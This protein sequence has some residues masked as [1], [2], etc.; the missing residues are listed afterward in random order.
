MRTSRRTILN[1]MSFAG[2]SNAWSPP[3]LAASKKLIPTPACSIEP[4]FPRVEWL[5]SPSGIDTQLPRFTWTLRTRTREARNLRQSAYRLLVALS[6]ALL[7]QGHGDIWDSGICAGGKL[8]ASPATTLSLGSH[9]IY[10]WTVRVWDE[11]NRPSRWAAPERFVTGLMD[12][13]DWRAQWIAAKPDLPALA[14]PPSALAVQV[15]VE[16]EPMPVFRRQF[17]L[18]KQIRFAVASTSGLGQYELLVNAQTVGHGVLNPGWTD[19]RKTVLYNTFD[20]TR[21]LRRGPNILGVMLGNG[22]YNVQRYP[23]RYTKFV[24]T[25]GQPKLILQLKII[26]MDGSEKTIISDQSWTTRPGP[27]LLSS[28]YGGEDYDARSEPPAWDATDRNEDWLPACEVQ[29]PGGVLRAQGIPPV[30]VARV[31]KPVVVTQP[32]PGV[33]VYDLGRNFAGWPTIVVRGPAGKTVRLLPAELL[34]EN[35]LVTQQS[36]NARPGNDVEFNYT[37]KGHGDEAWH[38]RFS[39][40]GF[41]YVQVEGAAPKEHAEP[42][43]PVLLSL[44]GAFLHTA[45]PQAGTFDSSDNLLAR[46]HCLIKNAL[47][48]NTFSVLTD[49]PQREKLGWL[50]Q[51]Y[52]NADTVFYN[53]DAVTIYEKMLND[54]K[55]SQLEDGLV[56][57][58]APEYVAFDTPSLAAFRDSPE[59]GSAVVL[60]PWAAYRRYGNSRILHDG[61]SA[62]QRYADYLQQKA[63]GGLLDYGLGDW[64]DIGPKP[65][66]E[67]QLT[68]KVLTATATYYGMLCTL[69][70]IAALLDKPDNIDDYQR[71]AASVKDAFNAKLFDPRTGHYDRNSQ[72]ANAMPLVLGLVPDGQRRAVLENLVADIRARQN[73]VSAGDIGFHYVVQALMEGGRG[74]VLFDMLSRTDPPSYAYQLAKGATALTEA[75]DANPTKSQD[76]F[77]LGHAETWFYGGL[78]GVRIDMS[79]PE[80]R[81]ILIAPQIVAGVAATSVRYRSVLGDVACGWRKR[82][83]F[84]KLRVEIPAGACGRVLLAGLRPEKIREGSKELSRAYG[85]LKTETDDAGTM[86]TIGSG[87]YDFTAP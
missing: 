50:E 87:G 35:G 45:L 57:E 53:E 24:G 79:A 34:D 40:Y 26:F 71:R 43:T 11:K 38:P 32:K 54:M 29:G 20:V 78:G 6:P 13:S 31:F 60:S 61:Y 37:L 28:A 63:H 62:M 19:Y 86:I 59:W 36:A 7:Q 66:G 22:L 48:N 75:W 12:A 81:R 67:A 85:V 65:P 14:G 2:L 73:H 64:Y 84:L 21:L 27:I 8:L 69:A 39:Y 3:I 77:M 82:D 30:A 80:D 18:A 56:P 10:W 41:R 5:Q 33:F 49:C 16:P 47:L 55:D 44:Q 42:D 4:A 76:H 1:L 9:R 70:R 23:G 68:S 58:I 15:A 74:D 17:R 25:F 46:I 52:L 83:G 72:T 51:T